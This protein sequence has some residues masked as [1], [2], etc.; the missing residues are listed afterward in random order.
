MG[1]LIPDRTRLSWLLLAAVT[2]SCPVASRA[3]SRVTVTT[4]RELRQLSG[5][6]DPCEIDLRGVITYSDTKRGVLYLQD[7]TGAAI[8]EVG[9]LGASVEA[10]ASVA[11]SGT[12]DARSRSPRVGRPRLTVLGRSTPG[13]DAPAPGGERRGAAGPAR[14]GGVGGDPRRDALGASGAGPDPA[15]ALRGGAVVPGLDR[16]PGRERVR[17]ALRLPRLAARRLDGRGARPAGD[18]RGADH[19]A[20][21]ELPALPGGPAARRVPAAALVRAHAWARPT[22]RACPTTAC[23]CAAWCGG[24]WMP[25]A[26]CWATGTARPRSRA[27]SRCRSTSARPSS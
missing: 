7:E 16:E 13:A 10:G 6:A 23:T 8:F 21:D 15:R 24:S 1:G 25:A 2:V 22:R 27:R 26:S 4:L 18:A 19:G 5:A 20:R 14:G 12:Y 17:L 11:L 9:D 3:P